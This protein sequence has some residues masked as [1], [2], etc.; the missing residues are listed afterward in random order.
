[1]PSKAVCWIEKAPDP[2][3]WDRVLFGAKKS[4]YKAWF[5]L[6]HRWL[7]FTQGAVFN[8]AAE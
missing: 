5:A 7:D 4:V 1:M 8:A 3:P 6:T 2:D